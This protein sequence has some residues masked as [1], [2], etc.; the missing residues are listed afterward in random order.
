M[1]LNL[2]LLSVIAVASLTLAACIKIE[3]YDTPYGDWDESIS[4]APDWVM[5]IG[6]PS[7]DTRDD[8]AFRES[9]SRSV[10][11]CLYLRDV[12]AFEKNHKTY[13]AISDSLAD[14]LVDIDVDRHMRFYTTDGRRI[15]NDGVMKDAFKKNKRMIAS[16]RLEYGGNYE[17]RSMHFLNSTVEGKD[18]TAEFD[19]VLGILINSAK[20]DGC[21]ISSVTFMVVGADL[22]LYVAYRRA[23]PGAEFET[24]SFSYSSA[25]GLKQLDVSGLLLLNHLNKVYENAHILYSSVGPAV[26]Q[27]FSNN[28]VGVVSKDIKH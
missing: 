4:E 15:L 28:N 5:E 1:K 14:V 19:K 7:L 24:M 2:L 27:N 9:L 11:Y 23:A 8:T 18:F 21:I 26:I 3:D 16:N 25:T 10:N 13:I 17:T 22:P 20:E 6:V 12:Y